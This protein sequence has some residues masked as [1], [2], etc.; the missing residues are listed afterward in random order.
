MN[1][2]RFVHL[3]GTKMK[4]WRVECFGTR[5][6]PR[7]VQDHERCLWTDEARDAMADQHIVLLEDFPKCSQD[8]APLTVLA[9]KIYPMRRAVAIPCSQKGEDAYAIHRLAMVIRTTARIQ[10]SS[11]RALRDGTPYVFVRGIVTPG[12][13][14]VHE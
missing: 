13:D 7:L 11:V 5:V 10:R 1:T 14:G 3:V 6:R 12:D 8:D 2:D 9:G 4:E